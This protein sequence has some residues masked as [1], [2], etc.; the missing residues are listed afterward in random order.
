[1]GGKK[2][3]DKIIE[4]KPCKCGSNNIMKCNSYIERPYKFWL[5]CLDCGNISGV[6]YTNSRFSSR[7]IFQD[8]T[9]KID[10]PEI[11]SIKKWNKEIDG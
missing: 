8:G 3:K 9:E 10:D 6:V 4:I 7:T 5:E 1:V 11:D 2:I